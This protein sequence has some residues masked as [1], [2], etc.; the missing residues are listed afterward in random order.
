[1]GRA[2]ALFAAHF[3]GLGADGGERSTSPGDECS[4][5]DGD[6]I[7]TSPE[8]DGGADCSSGVGDAGDGVQQPVMEATFT[9][10]GAQGQ[11]NT[12]NLHALVEAA[13]AAEGV[14]ES[15]SGGCFDYSGGGSSTG[16]DDETAD[17]ADQV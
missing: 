4:T 17:D 6:G 3:S 1:M 7:H 13:A 14:W 2:S 5:D 11:T 15:E 12:A 10:A 9:C 8:Q 16:S